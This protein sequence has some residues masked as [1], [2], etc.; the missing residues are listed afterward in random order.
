MR[1]TFAV[2]L[3]TINYALI[4]FLLKNVLLNFVIQ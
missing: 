2:F 1:E 3:R 4:N